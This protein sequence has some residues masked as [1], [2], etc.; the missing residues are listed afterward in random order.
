M[1]YGEAK[2]GEVP[3]PVRDKNENT[4]DY[5][6][7]LEKRWEQEFPDKK[8]VM[9]PDPDRMSG[10]NKERAYQTKSQ[11]YNL[12]WGG[13]T[14]RYEVI[15]L[16]DKQRVGLMDSD[17]NLLMGCDRK[18]WEQ[19]KANVTNNVTPNVTEDVVGDIF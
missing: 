5:S 10:E 17:M 11:Y 9:V 3:V 16:D 7:K 15:E 19:A 14:L 8:C 2:H 4:Y 18:L 13:M 12:Q 1:L 6:L